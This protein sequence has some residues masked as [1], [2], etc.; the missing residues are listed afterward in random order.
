V[1]GRLGR[2]RADLRL[3]ARAAAVT[4]TATPGPAVG[5]LVLAVAQAFVSIGGVWLTKVIVDRLAAGGDA[6]GPALLYGATLLF[7]ATA[8][9]IKRVLAAL[10]EER[11]VGEVDRRLMAAGVRLCDLYRVER[12]AFG[13]ELEV[14]GKAIYFV[15]RS[16][17]LLDRAISVPVTLAGVLGLLIRVNPVLPAVLGAVTVGHILAEQRMGWVKHEAMV[18]RSRPAREMDYCV[19]MATDPAGAKEV[20]AFGIG[21]FFHARFR[22]RALAAV[23][24]MRAVRL[25]GART[26]ILWALAHGAVVAGGFV[27]VADRAASG[28]LSPGDVALFLNVVVQA[29][30]VSWG[31]S[32][33]FVYGHETLLNVRKVLPFLEDAHPAIALPPAGAGLESPAVLEQGI[34]L[35][36]VRF[37]YPE[38]DEPVLNGLSALLPP[39][40]VTAMVGA[41][42]AG[43]STLVKLLT[44]MYDPESGEVTVDGTPL[45]ELDLD[46]WR[47]RVAAVHQDFS[48]LAL[49]M[50]E[51]VAVGGTGERLGDVRVEEA[52]HWAG[53]DEVAERL[54]AGL[55]TLLTRRFTGGADLSGGEWQKVAL[56]RGA[57][58]DAAL[59]IL[60]EPTAGLD[61]EAE[62]RLY[63]RFQEL[64]EGRTALLISH[65]F[66]TVRMAD[67]IVVIEDGRVIESGS[68]EE[69]LAMGGRYSALYEMQASRYR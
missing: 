48:R 41:N 32:F 35:A 12:P 17:L 58:R 64:V 57:V 39:G 50:R 2:A 25:K 44:R 1:S 52:I 19:R 23:K 30:T 46:G 27:Y 60:D 8:E 54:P 28:A 67:H 43:K 29:A 53:V 65:R 15:P 22:E 68:H 37:M 47:L 56:A 4:V 5:S 45:A 3:L 31:M 16:I 26:T 9:P 49:T 11:A 14:L 7:A 40:K 6:T 51:N 10:V 13:D 18:R 66:S 59:V 63:K 61:P 62:Y 34:A 20:R 55:D 38:G 24:E 36:N 42:G 33:I 21:P 69:L